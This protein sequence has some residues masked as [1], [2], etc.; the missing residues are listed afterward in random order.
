MENKEGGRPKE[1]VNDSNFPNEWKD[2]ILDLYSNGASDVE[3][4]ALI[5]SWRGTLSNDLWDR[6][7]LEEVEFSETIKMGKLLSNAWWEKEGRENLKNNKFN[8]VGWYMNM[9][10]R[11]GWADKTQTDTNVNLKTGQPITIIYKGKELD[12]KK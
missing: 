7:L 9:K 3:V 12:I 10:N 11:F 6:W 4:K 8:Y 1:T 2:V 5:T